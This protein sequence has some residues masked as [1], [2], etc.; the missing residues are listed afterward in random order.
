MEILSSSSMLW[1]TYKRRVLQSSAALVDLMYV[2]VSFVSLAAFLLLWVSVLVLH[3]YDVSQFL[4]ALL[5]VPVF[6]C[7]DP[8][9]DSSAHSSIV[10][11]PWCIDCM[12]CPFIS[13]LCAT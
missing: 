11:D 5:L 9:D 13:S 6:V 2:R 7:I 10:E 4:F 3:L 12:L 1:M 8:L